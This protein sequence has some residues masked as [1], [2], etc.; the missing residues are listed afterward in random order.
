VFRGGYAGGSC[1]CWRVVR[2]VVREWDSWD[3]KNG[4][5]R[6]VREPDSDGGLRGLRWGDLL[7]PWKKRSIN[8]T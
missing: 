6:E 4:Q 5:G 2:K 1:S 3:V 8:R 7:V